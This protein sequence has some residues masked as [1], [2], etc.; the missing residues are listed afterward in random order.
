MNPF[1]DTIVASPW[2]ATGVDVPAIHG[3]VLHECLRGIEHVR[4][5][6]RSAGLLIHGEAGSGKTHLLKRLRAQ[7]AP[8]QPT[9]TDRRECLY[10]WVRLQTS[11]RMIWRTLRRTLVDDWFRPV[12]NG[13]SQFD[14]ILFHR[15]AE[16]RVAEGDLEPWYEYMREEHPDGLAELMDRIAD[17]LHLDRN[18]AVAF[19]HIAFGRHRRDLRAWLAG[20]SLPQAALE[21]MDLA[22]DEGT[23]EEREDLARQV[24][25]MLC[26]LAGNGLPI[27][28]SFDQVEALQMRPGDTDALFQFGQ[29]TSTLHDST[30]N[31]LLVS[32]VQSAFATELKD[33]ARSADYDRMTSLGAYSLDPLDR[34]QAEQ[35]IAARLDSADV[36]DL[37]ESRSATWPLSPEAFDAL[38]ASGG[39]SPRKL[40]SRSAESFETWQSPGTS[41]VPP[42]PPPERFLQERWESLVEEKQAANGPESTEEILRHGVP[43]LVSLVAPDQRLVQD[44]HL[45][46]VSLIFEGPAGRTGLSACTQSNMTSLATRLK[47]LKL[48][49]ASERLQRLVIVRD[50]R[51]PLTK[52]ARAARQHLEELEA[53]HAVILHPAVEVLAAIDALRALLSDAKSGDLDCQG[54]PLSPRTVEEWFRTH[55]AGELEAFVGDVLGQSDGAAAKESADVQSLEA[56]IAFLGESPVAPLVEVAESLQQSVES[57]I[58]TARRHPDQ[59]GLLGQPPSVLFRIEEGSER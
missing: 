25:L 29:L 34:R 52:T 41:I 7:L 30:T 35:L 14:R 46:D 15:L 48:Q 5:Q 20:D 21:R 4:S 10:V 1:R 39:V 23:D 8:Q 43:L 37:P 31:V 53:Q 33:H 28:L 3:N 38:F 16:I 9:A 47:R 32:A 54:Q 22:Q 27:V 11:P 12:D 36:R 51:V 19:M 13:K 2:E 24:V 55:L 59:F 58:E 40:L 17:N 6:G 57:L 44:E 45:P 49:F 18:T 50:S 56:L 42:P 26:S